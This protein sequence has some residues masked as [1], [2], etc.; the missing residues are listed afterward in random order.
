MWAHLV[1]K[2]LHNKEGFK[3]GQAQSLKGVKG[4]AVRFLAELDN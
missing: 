4:R 2:F 1:I 3:E